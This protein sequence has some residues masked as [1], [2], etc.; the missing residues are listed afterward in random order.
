MNAGLEPG[1][2]MSGTWPLLPRAR[3]QLPGH[4]NVC[5]HA[6]HE[7]DATHELVDSEVTKLGK[8]VEIF[9]ALVVIIDSL[10][11]E[12]AAPRAGVMGWRA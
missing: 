9:N 10:A 11:L 1:S 4:S 2:K 6:T 7:L 8:L 3:R 12:G 5:G